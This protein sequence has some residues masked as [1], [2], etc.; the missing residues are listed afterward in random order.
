MSIRA[1]AEKLGRSPST[2]SR[3]LRRNAH[4]SGGYRPFEAH[5]QATARRARPHR[6]R[7]D[8]HPELRD[9]WPTC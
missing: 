1:I 5:R 7:L 2:I 8:T 9:R 4:A 3:E 6:R